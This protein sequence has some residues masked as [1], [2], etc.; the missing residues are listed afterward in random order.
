MPDM[1]NVFASNPLDA[2]R[3][4]RLGREQAPAIVVDDFLRAPGALVDFAASARFAA[5]KN[6]YPGLRAEPLPQPYVIAIIQSL[7]TLIGETFGLP[8]EG[9]LDT[10]AYFG[11]ATLPPGALSPLQRVPH[12]DTANPRQIAVLHYLCGAG[13]GGTAFYRHRATGF[14]TIDAERQ[15]SYYSALERELKTGGPPP[16]RYVSG[17]DDLFEE[18][19]RVEARFNRLLIYPSRI[20]HSANVNPEAGLSA[21]PRTGRLTANVF[22]AYR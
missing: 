15:Q 17:D 9:D 8:V 11:L 4:L 18:T 6:W 21:D 20:L 1:T 7:H 10:N 2:V 19:G 13:H 3:I 12:F 14:E 22:L 16:A 5:P